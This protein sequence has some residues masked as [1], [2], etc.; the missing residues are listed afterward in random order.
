MALIELKEISLHLEGKPILDKLSL[1]VEEKSKVAVKG[2]SGAGKTALLK[3]VLGVFKPREGQVTIDG[4]L[5][6]PENFDALRRRIS[7]IPQH[8]SVFEDQ[9]LKEYI[10]RPF[11]FK[12]NRAERPSRQA[13]EQALSSL[14]LPE[15]LLEQ[16]MYKLSGGER[17][18][19]AIARA[20]LLGRT[21]M[22]VDEPTSAI[23]DQ[24]TDKVSDAILGNDE[25]TVLSISHDDRWLSR[26]DFVLTLEDGRIAA[27]ASE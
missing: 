19:A 25:L 27:P 10:E 8:V 16:S 3:V 4:L 12:N 5:L 18:R 20:L 15:E 13:L 24:N 1:F 2:P 6:R 17:Q 9:T 26:C 21:L 11:G 23:D 22:L 7:F 14:N